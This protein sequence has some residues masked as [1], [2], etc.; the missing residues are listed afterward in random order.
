ME[1]HGGVASAD[2][3][4][5]GVLPGDEGGVCGEG[6]AVGDHSGCFG[7]QRCPCRGGGFCDQDVSGTEPTEVSLGYN[8][9]G[10]R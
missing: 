6:A 1:P 10:K 5:N 3:S 9:D 2:D 7:E 8:A 4:G